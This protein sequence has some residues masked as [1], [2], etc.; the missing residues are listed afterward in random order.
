M[1]HIGHQS[2]ESHIFYPSDDFSGFEVLV[3][4]VSTSLSEII[5]KI[6]NQ[7]GRLRFRGKK[8]KKPKTLDSLGN[9]SQ[10]TSFFPEVDDNTNATSLGCPNAFFDSKD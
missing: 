6:P 4:R 10:R 9:F 2:L 5:N 8:K 1:K 3:G 7:T